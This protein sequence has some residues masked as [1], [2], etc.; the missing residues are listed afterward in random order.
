[1]NLRVLDWFS[2][3]LVKIYDLKHVKLMS[4]LGTWL[5]CWFFMLWE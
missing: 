4:L 1:V 3:F 5:K 2:E